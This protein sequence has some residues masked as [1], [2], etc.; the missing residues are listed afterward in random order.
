MDKS[1]CMMTNGQV[2]K[3]A[4][5]RQIGKHNMEERKKN[6][7]HLTASILVTLAHLS[8]CNDV[9][10][11]L[12]NYVP[13]E[14]VI[15]NYNILRRIMLTFNIFESLRLFFIVVLVNQEKQCSPHVNNWW[16][17]II[18]RE[19]LRP[20]C[21][22]RKLI[23]EIT[24]LALLITATFRIGYYKVNYSFTLNKFLLS[25]PPEIVYYDHRGPP[26]LT[27]SK[28]LKSRKLCHNK[29]TRTPNTSE[30]NVHD[31]SPNSHEAAADYDDRDKVRQPHLLLWP[32]FRK[33]YPLS[34]RY[35]LN[36]HLLRRCY[37]EA[38]RNLAIVN[39][40]H[41]PQYTNEYWH[42]MT[43]C[44]LVCLYILT[45][46]S[47][48]F[49]ILTFFIYI[50]GALTFLSLQ[51]VATELPEQQIP[52]STERSKYD[53]NSSLNDGLYNNSSLTRNTNNKPLTL[54]EFSVYIVGSIETFIALCDFYLLFVFGI[55]SLLT[56]FID[57]VV[58]QMRLDERIDEIIFIRSW[59]KHLKDQ[60]S[61]QL[62]LTR[63]D[64]KMATLHVVNEINNYFNFVVDCDLLSS[65]SN[66]I[67]I[68][69]ILANTI[70][71]LKYKLSE[72]SYMAMFLCNQIIYS[73]IYGLSMCFCVARI[74]SAVSSAAINHLS[75]DMCIS[76]LE[77]WWPLYYLLSF[78][79]FATHT[80][81]QINRI[82]NSF[83][84]CTASLHPPSNT[85]IV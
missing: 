38:N 5:D 62:C 23:Y 84:R 22:S 43:K 19:P 17:A 73:F 39:F 15:K 80:H 3:R 68:I 36:K 85:M 26:Q 70:T 28:K 41:P 51:L 61:D 27:P 53:V 82:W 63:T 69:L 30:N 46:V 25:D 50:R 18:L 77:W 7:K 55:V 24:F 13:F 12:S 52:S 9:V 42:A 65:T 71:G 31:E 83:T 72:W 56:L 49:V 66:L 11:V 37:Q 44:R 64:I 45:T 76:K 81:T 34:D 16:L 14:F 2:V 8:G 58:W 57:L 74:N 54:A 60:H 47:L 10:E 59:H 78:V 79:L 35:R 20:V 67:T 6:C 32:N 1:F 4:T 29:K 75:L 40:E 48:V 33:S 21:D